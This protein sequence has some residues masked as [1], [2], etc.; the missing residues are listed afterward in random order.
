M[1]SKDRIKNRTAQILRPIC[2]PVLEKDQA[3]ARVRDFHARCVMLT[4][5]KSATVGL[6]PMSG[7]CF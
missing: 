5:N 2:H 4:H 7:E 1:R 6:D 3:K